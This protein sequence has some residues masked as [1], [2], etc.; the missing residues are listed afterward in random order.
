MLL[1]WFYRSLMSRHIDDA[2]PLPQRCLDHL[3]QCAACREDYESQRTVARTLGGETPFIPTI[4][5]PFLHGKIMAALDRPDERERIG[6]RLPRRALAFA[7]AIAAA[8]L[9]WNHLS[10]QRAEQNAVAAIDM[11]VAALTAKAQQLSLDKIE[12]RL[13]EPMKKE[14]EALVSD[15]KAAL[16]L[17]AQNFLPSE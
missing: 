4:S 7:L 12:T 3:A 6:A 13:N 10:R 9:V 5:P 11:Q 1:C 16:N 8:A 15:A 17:L 14:A 2:T